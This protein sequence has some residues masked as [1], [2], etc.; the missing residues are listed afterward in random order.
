MFMMP[1]PPTSSDT[2]AIAASSSDMAFDDALRLQHLLSCGCWKSSLL[3]V[4][5]SVALAQQFA[6][7]LL[8]PRASKPS[9]TETSL[10]DPGPPAVWPDCRKPSTQ[11]RA[12]EIGIRSG[13]PGPRFYLLDLI[14]IERSDRDLID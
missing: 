1:M 13:R 9:A 8:R 12:V 5:E 7:L 11:F 2:E 6:H 10:G 4:A 3:R 14:S